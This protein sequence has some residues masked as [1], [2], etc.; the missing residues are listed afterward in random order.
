MSMYKTPSKRSGR[1]LIYKDIKWNIENTN[2]IKHMEQD[3]ENLLRW[4]EVNTNAPEYRESKDLLYYAFDRY[5]E[6]IERRNEG[7]SGG[8]FCDFLKEV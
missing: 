4:R 7:P 5:E 1:K 3:I 6:L 8:G 2:V